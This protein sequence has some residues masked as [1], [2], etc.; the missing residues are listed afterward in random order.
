MSEDVRRADAFNVVGRSV[1]S[2]DGLEK[3]TGAA[4]FTADLSRPGM[5]WGR[6]LRSPLPHARILRIDARKALALRGVRAVV[7]GAD[8]PRH[9]FG[10]LIKDQHV[11]AFDKVRY[12]GDEVALVAATDP[13]IAREAVDLIEVEYEPL[14]AVFDI[15]DAIREGAPLVHEAAR[16]IA[17]QISIVRGD[18]A[19]AF[20]RCHEIVEE[21]F[22]T[23]KVHQAY[24][25]THACLA[26]VDDRG[27][28][29]LWS[30]N[31]SPGRTRFQLAQALDIPIGNIRVHQAFVGGGFGGK[32]YQHVVFLS[33]ALAM[34]VRRPVM[35][36]FDRTEDFACTLPRV[37][38]RIHI[39]MGC[40]RDG[41][42]LG[43]EM[44]IVADNGAYSVNAPAVVDTAATRVDSLYRIPALRN[45]AMLVYTNQ[46]PTGMFRGFGNPQS[47]FAVE[48]CMDM[49]A[50]RVG[51]DPVE[52]RLLNGT[53]TGDVTIHGW[54][55]RSCALS[56]CI[57][58]VAD[59][60]GMDHA[61]G[62]GTTT[63]ADKKGPLRGVGLGCVI[64]VNGNRSVFAAFEGSCARVRLDESGF[65]Y[66]SSSCGDIG[67]GA[68]TTFAQIAAEILGLPMS[69]MRVERS[70]TS[71]TGFGLGAFASRVTVLAGNAVREA[72]EDLRNRI[73]GICADEWGVPEDDIRLEGGR[74]TAS[75]TGSERIP[76]EG[77][78]L[79]DVARLYTYAHG[80]E[81]LEG[82]GHFTPDDVVIADK[83]TKYGNISGTYTFGA[84]G[85]EIEIDPDTGRITCKRL[86]AA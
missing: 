6:A 78:T 68:S 14:P 41:R 25:E 56:D 15:D 36:V 17:H 1:T 16:N 69:A 34:K 37:P 80:G 30:G 26:D 42:L 21:D 63:K 85:V 2:V 11:V 83:K 66:V 40:D 20:S 22:E 51:L 75:A 44:R 19:G 64:H 12:I 50:E 62:A 28:V 5:L 58:K 3:V 10:N 23:S 33:V 48:S 32:A 13:D 61:K 70:D 82:K 65:A 39:K 8:C 54:K 45:E 72:A 43:K 4:R 81:N 35:M 49:L 27:R 55:I 38:M 84:Q 18:I 31:Q 9:T 79:G 74:A 60:I 73:V 86:V 67:Q 76:A 52:I 7:T 24:L 47:T 59:K 53:Q 57:R 71:I 77:L 46:E 29:E